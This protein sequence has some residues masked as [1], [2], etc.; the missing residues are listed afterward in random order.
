MVVRPDSQQ[1]DAYG[2]DSIRGELEYP[3]RYKA[4]NFYVAG[5]V[6]NCFNDLTTINSAE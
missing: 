1:I 5:D 3:E 2:A 6:P 4:E